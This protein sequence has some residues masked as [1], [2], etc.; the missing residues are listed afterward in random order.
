MITLQHSFVAAVFVALAFL[1]S[2][3]T[4]WLLFDR[5]P[6]IVYGGFT[7]AD[8]NGIPSTKFKAGTAMLLTREFCV[9]SYQPAL[10]DRRFVNMDDG[11]TYAIPSG[12]V[13]LPPGCVKS[14]RAIP[15]PSYLPPGPYQFQAVVGYTNNPWVSGR[16][17]APAPVIEIVP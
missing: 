13:L 6:P 12:E 7:T 8:M 14:T 5:A 16:V 11:L 4:Y 3:N 9:S 17:V 15:I 1:F 2:V 10:I